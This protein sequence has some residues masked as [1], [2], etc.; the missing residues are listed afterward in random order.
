MVWARDEERGNGSSESGYEN[1][2][3]KKRERKTKKR[4]VGYD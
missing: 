1:K 3:R 4:M 2:R